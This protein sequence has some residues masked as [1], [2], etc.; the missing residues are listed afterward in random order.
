M[1]L[2]SNR[3]VDQAPQVVV[4]HLEELARQGARQMLV[5]ALGSPR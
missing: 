2:S 1:W 3:N 4:D 5:T